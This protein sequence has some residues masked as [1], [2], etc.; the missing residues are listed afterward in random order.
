MS[1]RIAKANKKRLRLGM[2]KM[3]EAIA[4]EESKP[5]VSHLPRDWRNRVLNESST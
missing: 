1:W 3:L 2:E 5:R 4:L